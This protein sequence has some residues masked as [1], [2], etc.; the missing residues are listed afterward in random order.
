MF[1]TGSRPYKKAG[2][3]NGLWSWLKCVG[4]RDEER[5]QRGRMREEIEMRKYVM[6][7]L[8]NLNVTLHIMGKRLTGLCQRRQ[9][10][11]TAG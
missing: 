9:V 11:E 3:T 5:K 1:I 2:S 7:R 10:S 4:K 8:S 6:T